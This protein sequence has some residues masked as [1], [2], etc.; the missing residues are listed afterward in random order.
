MADEYS[1]VKSSDDLKGWF[2]DQANPSN[3]HDIYYI[4]KS[5]LD[6][7][8][9][10]AMDEFGQRIVKLKNPP[11]PEGE[12]GDWTEIDDSRAANWLASTYKIKKVSTP[13]VVEA[14]Q[15]VAHDN[16]FHPVRKYFDGLKWDGEKRLE[17]MLGEYIGASN[18][19]PEL[20]QY[21]R[22]ISRIWMM[23]AVAR[24]YQPGCKADYVLI[25]EGEQRKGKSTFFD[26]LGGDWFSD[27]PFIVGDKDSYQN[28]AGKMIV[29]L[30]EIDSFKKADAEK[31]KA[32]FSS[33]I[34]N[35]RPS[36]GR[37]AMKFPRQCVFAGT[38]NQ[39]EYFR[40]MTGNLRYMPVYVR[41]LDTKYL[42]ENRDQLWAE[43]VHLYKKG[44]QWL[45]DHPEEIDPPLELRWWPDDDSL[46]LMARQQ[47]MRE[48]IDPLADDI[49]IWLDSQV[50]DWETGCGMA[51]VTIKRILTDVMD[52]PSKAENMVYKATQIG[53]ILKK[54]GWQKRQFGSDLDRKEFGRTYYIKRGVD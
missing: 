45:V 44:Q 10:L 4:L 1:K 49:E 8:G 6:W 24:I 50:D 34:D 54:L 3:L 36:Y 12:V 2:I 42:L 53:K 43:A 23:S 47:S 15:L 28:L 30:Q 13:T 33:R 29:E 14:V 5:H 39:N 40:D 11:F 46:N 27:T 26:K 25:L 19:T 51:P 35:Y 18:K 16:R 52:V 21:N 17:D 38:T 48:T 37:R 9:V 20:M 22:L 32:F 41:K 7:E 31:L